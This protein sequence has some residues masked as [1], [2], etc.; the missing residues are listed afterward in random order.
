MLSFKEPPK[1]QGLDKAVRE[2]QKVDKGI[3]N[4]LRKDMRSEL[5]P[6]L[7]EIVGEVPVNAPIS[8]MVGG[9]RTSW[10]GV[11]GGFSFRPNAKSKKGGYVPVITM[12]LKSKGKYAGF[13]I[14]EM[15]GS[16]NLMFSKNK[17][18][19]KQFVSILKE[20]SGSPFKAG[21]F[22]YSEFLKRRPDV[23]KAAI[24]IINKFAEEFNKRIG[25]R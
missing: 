17:K 24:E 2:L 3:I 10:A 14:A 18:K 11:K 22:G 23:R 6:T 15:A 19:G 21:R 25:I 4:K 12:T 7:N 1:V 16:K 5:R 9:H 8:G 20:R 13:E